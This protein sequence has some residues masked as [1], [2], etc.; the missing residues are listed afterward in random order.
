MASSVRRHRRDLALLK[1]LGFTRR[2]LAATVAWHATTSTVVA[3]LVGVPV[4][5]VIGR[6]LWILFAGELDVVVEP[7]VPVAALAVLVGVALVAANAAAAAPARAARGV[8]AS[9]L[10]RSE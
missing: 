2:Q 6:S 9:V 4:G 7:S 10:L 8:K 5:V 1:T 3:L